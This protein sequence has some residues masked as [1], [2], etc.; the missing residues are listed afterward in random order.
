MLQGGHTVE[1]TLDGHRV[2]SDEAGGSALQFIGAGI[3][4]CRHVLQE[5]AGNGAAYSGLTVTYQARVGF[6]LDET[7]IKQEVELHGL[8]RGYPD[9]SFIGSRRRPETE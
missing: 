5:T 8:D 2:R 7:A 4:P 3:L 6:N 9:L 1:E